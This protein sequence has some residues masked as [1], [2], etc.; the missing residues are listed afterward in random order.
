MLN[1]C[2]AHRLRGFTILE[3]LV[4]VLILAFGILGYASLQGKMQV[5]QFEAQQR[6]QAIIIL[7]DMIARLAT[8]R[9]A[10]ATYVTAT[11]LG[12]G[13]SQ[14]AS[15]TGLAI[16]VARDQCEWS[17]SLKGA[18]ETEGTSKIG[19]MLG[20]RGCIEQIT[21]AD[22]TVGICTPSVYRVTVVWQGTV[23]TSAPSLLCGQNLYGAETLRRA[24]AA[25]ITIGLPA[26]TS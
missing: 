1:S 25:Q 23:T 26:C 21:A 11:P 2:L 3:V 12:T 17:Q 4:T 13:D 5:S 8:N 19:A 16:G 9:T 22:P 20:A 18:A 7:N 24:L 10:A 14:P 6:S 15:C